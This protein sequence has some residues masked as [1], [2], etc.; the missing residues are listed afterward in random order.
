MY[1]KTKKKWKLTERNLPAIVRPPSSISDTP[2]ESSGDG[3]GL[4]LDL[5]GQG[6][7]PQ[8][9]IHLRVLKNTVKFI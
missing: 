3:G 7:L 6:H 9:A 5:Y 2:G 4:S 1:A 8:S